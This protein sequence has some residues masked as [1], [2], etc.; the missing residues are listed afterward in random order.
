MNRIP[1]NMP[2]QAYRTF[3]ITSPLATHWRRATCEE[4]DCANYLHG[5]RSV[6]DESTELGQGQ[7]HYIRHDTSR[8]HTEE[9]RPDGL[10]EFTFEA[11][12]TCFQAAAHKVQVRPELYLSR[13]G[14]WRGST[15]APL[16][17]SGPDPWL[18][19]FQTNQDRLATLQARG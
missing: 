9:R 1:P 2:V 5:W 12:Q 8:R 7:A 15:T 14:D 13:G 17:H 16:R 3:E 19:E 11:G 6:I 10:T 18:D 4:V